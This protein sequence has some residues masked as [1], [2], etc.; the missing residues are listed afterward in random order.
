MDKPLVFEPNFVLG[1]T[2][3]CKTDFYPE[4]FWEGVSTTL[5]NIELPIRKQET[6]GKL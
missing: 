1:G 4:L 3:G 2:C 5:G 6:M